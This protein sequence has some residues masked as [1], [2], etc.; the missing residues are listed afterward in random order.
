M[1]DRLWVYVLVAEG[2]EGGKAKSRLRSALLLG[3][4]M[5]VRA[6]LPSL[7][8]DARRSCRAAV[9]LLLPRP[10]RLQQGC[11]AVCDFFL[12][13]KNL[14][15][16]VA[17]S[18]W[19]RP[20]ASLSLNHF[21]C[22]LRQTGIHCI[23]VRA[24]QSPATIAA[25]SSHKLVCLDS[26][27]REKFFRVDFSS[28]FFFWHS[29]PTRRVLSSCARNQPSAKALNLSETNTTISLAQPSHS[30]QISNQVTLKKNSSNLHDYSKGSHKD[31]A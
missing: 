22:I 11:N 26:E 20:E 15:C 14:G 29:F 12:K 27:A 2:R 25:S 9:Q 24:Q 7:S 18:A 13:K 17:L 3:F 6:Q 16:A 28:P 1:L 23:T 10:K 8:R 30:A 21:R 5:D 19:I 31:N 4:G